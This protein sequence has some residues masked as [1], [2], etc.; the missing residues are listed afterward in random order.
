MYLKK[1]LPEVLQ[2]NKLRCSSVTHVE[3]GGNHLPSGS[4]C[5]PTIFVILTVIFAVAIPRLMVIG[6]LPATDEG[7]FAYFAQIAHASL[8]AGKGLPNTGPLMLYPLLLNWVF[9]FDANPLVALRLIDMLFAMVAGYA[10]YRVIEMESGSRFGAFLIC[11]LFLFTM[12]QPT[13]IQYGFKNSMYAAYVPL[14]TALWLG[15]TAPIGT[16]TRRWITIGVLLSV[17]VLLRETFLPLIATGALAILLQRGFRS[18]FQSIVG[19]IGSG[20]LIVGIIIAARGGIA[21]LLESYQDAAKIYTA[22]AD[23]RTELFFSSGKQ[24]IQEANLSL[25]I[26]S[27]GFLV[28]LLRT[29]GKNSVTS[30][31]KLG[32]WLATTLVPLIEPASKI[33]FPY[34]FSVCLPGLAGLAA[35]GWRNICDGS[36]QTLRF[37]LASSTMCI[38]LFS[39]LIPRTAELWGNWSQARLVLSTFQSGHWPETLT[40]NSNYLIAAKVIRQVVPS[41][42]TI[43]ISGYMYSLYPL[44]NLLPPKPEFSNLTNTII[45]MDLSEHRLREALLR[46]P[47]DIVMTTSR[48]DWPGKP[49]LLAAVRGTGIY[50]EIAEIPTTNNRAY[51]NFGGFIF[52][53]KKHFPCEK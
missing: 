22:I 5:T 48:T 49:E 51:G 45:E 38:A 28:T 2:L 8:A 53:A 11:L 18:F 25:A 3:T 50:E 10:F 47:P 1:Q 13:F 24:F 9:A 42:G 19:A 4:P 16:S 39:M 41:G 17:A 32:L 12:N 46:C 35:L 29:L 20:L 43:A 6:G 37:H 44:T 26:A 34:H 31:S 30:L 7:V 14:F 27:V 36:R 15:L 21:S 33:G 52:R 23:K 40:D